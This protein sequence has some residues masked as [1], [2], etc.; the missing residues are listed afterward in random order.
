M[1]E[2]SE[3]GGEGDAPA[4]D[5]RSESAQAPH[6]IVAS[7]RLEKVGGPGVHTRRIGLRRQLRAGAR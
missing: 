7:G 2:D 1:R 3:S 4:D 6:R 5:H